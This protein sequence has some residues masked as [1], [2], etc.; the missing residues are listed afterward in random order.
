VT[1]YAISPCISRDALLSSK[2]YRNS[3]IAT[4]REDVGASAEANGCFGSTES[5]SRANVRGRR[6]TAVAHS[7]FCISSWR[8]CFSGAEFAV[9][10]GPTPTGWDDQIAVAAHMRT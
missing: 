8:T 4:T 7:A 9:T 2:L 6:I 10:N 1:V 3:V 5:T